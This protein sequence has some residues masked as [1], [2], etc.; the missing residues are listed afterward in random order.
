MIKNIIWKVIIGFIILIITAIFL[1]PFLSLLFS[2][3]SLGKH[4]YR[5]ISFAVIAGNELPESVSKEELIQS[6]I[7]YTRTHLWRFSDSRPYP[8]KPLDYLIEGVGWCDYHAKILCKLL[9]IKGIHTRYA[10]LLNKEGISPHTVAE[11]YVNGRWCGVDP[12]FGIIY[13][14]QAGQMVELEK[15]TPAMIARIPSVISIKSN[16][17]GL[18]EQIVHIA[19]KTYPLPHLPQRSESFLSEK[20]IFDFVASLHVKIFGRKFTDF[21]QDIFIKHY[22]VAIDDPVGRLWFEARN[23]DLY[24][25][26]EKAKLIYDQLLKDY[27]EGTFRRRTIVFLSQ[28]L[29]KQQR[30]EEARII[31]QQFLTEYPNDHWGS[32]CNYYIGLCYEKLSDLPKAVVYY[33]QAQGA[34]FYPAACLRL[35]ALLP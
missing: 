12:L 19:K 30:F 27:P 17:P 13:Y 18:F 10:F 15:V 31:L 16:N 7:D 3:S 2:R 22:I 1:S 24:G 14:D 29:I 23:Y 32:D 28:L 6:A 5:E 26:L 4:L 34:R 8:G 33:K 25:R 9:A 11:V 35:P 21:Y 20:H